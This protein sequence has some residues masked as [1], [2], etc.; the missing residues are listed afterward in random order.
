M[1]LPGQPAGAVNTVAPNPVQNA[2][3]T[4]IVARLLRK[5]AIFAVPAFVLRAVLGEMAGP[6][7]LAST[8]VIPEKLLAIEYKFRFPEIE[9][10]LRAILNRN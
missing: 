9:P 10:A 2:E 1:H 3:F 4:R 5:P 8:R 7:L 6:L